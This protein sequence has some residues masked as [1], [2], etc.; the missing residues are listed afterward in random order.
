[1][2]LSNAVS[3]PIDSVLFTVIAFSLP[4][5]VLR[6]IIWANILLKG[7]TSMVTWPLIYTVKDSAVNDDPPRPSPDTSP[8][9]ATTRAGR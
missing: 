7:V 4:S 5:E 2:I 8:P 1:M 6:S 9:R 3:I